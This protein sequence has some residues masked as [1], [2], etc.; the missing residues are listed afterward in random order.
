MVDAKKRNTQE[1]FFSP[2]KMKDTESDNI[3][4]HYQHQKL[5]IYVQTF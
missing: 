5:L 4:K 3:T 1:G 2:Q